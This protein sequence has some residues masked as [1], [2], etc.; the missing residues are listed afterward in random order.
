MSRSLRDRTI[1]AL[2]W[3][4]LAVYASTALRS[5]SKLVLANILAPS[6]F[7][8]LALGLLATETV[9]LVRR[10]GLH[11]A[12]IV[13]QDDIKQAADTAFTM[14]MGVGGGLF[15]GLYLT[16]PII[17]AF[18]G[19]S[20][21]TEVIQALSIILI[22]HSMGQVPGALMERELEFKELFAPDLLSTVTRFGVALALGLQGFG[23]WSLV[24]AEIAAVLVSTISILYLS[25]Y[26]PS[27]AFDLHIAKEILGFGAEITL[28]GFASF[29][30]KRVD[31]FAIGWLLG[32]TALGYY[33]IALAMANLP[34]AWFNQIPTKALFPTFSKLDRN[35]QR[36]LWYLSLRAISLLSFPAG[37]GIAVIAPEIVR[38]AIGPNWLP[39]VPVLRVLIVYGMMRSLSSGSGNVLKTTGNVTV[40]SRLMVAHAILMSVLVFPLTEVAGLIGAGLALILSSLVNNIGQLYYANRA[41]GIAHRRFLLPFAKYIT[42]AAVMGYSVHLV[43]QQ[44]R[45]ATFLDLGLLVSLG[46]AVYFLG[47][48]L[49]DRSFLRELYLEL[50]LASRFPLTLN[51]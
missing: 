40:Y 31:D 25:T 35:G 50:E 11:Q 43:N 42:L 26:T 30:Y 36:R 32:S 29:V 22:L 5:V 16:S 46:V 47:I 49:V 41:L 13:Q 34:Q 19:E 10:L 37:V 2:T 4:T 44:L 15:V 6:T 45:T 9:N 39:A 33:G 20:E 8:L 27:F 28:S 38:I 21:L 1:S 3:V 24:W 17:A 18:F 51:R 7:G 12:L 23:V 48:L 14:L